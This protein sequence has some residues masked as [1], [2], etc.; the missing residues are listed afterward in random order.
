MP[1]LG[2][3]ERLE[4]EETIMTPRILRAVGIGMPGE[5]SYPARAHERHIFR[6]AQLNPWSTRFRFGWILSWDG[7]FWHNAIG[8]KGKDWDDGKW[9]GGG[10]W[11]RGHGPIAIA[12]HRRRGSLRSARQFA[13]NMECPCP[14]TG[15]LWPLDFMHAEGCSLYG[16]RGDGSPWA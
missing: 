2:G 4:K 14:R 15:W 1:I 12:R 8:I 3:G 6:S 9:L 11:H 7:L 10:S 13:R 5:K 16:G